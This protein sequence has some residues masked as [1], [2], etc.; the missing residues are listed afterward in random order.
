MLFACHAVRRGDACAQLG[1]GPPPLSLK[2]LTAAQLGAAL[3]ALVCDPAYEAAA[4]RVAVGLNQEDGLEAA[5]LS[6]HRT[7]VG[8]A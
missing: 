6:V 4:A 5:L 7:L 3:Q 2:G 1:V 8:G